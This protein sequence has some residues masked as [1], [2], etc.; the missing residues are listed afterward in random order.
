MTRILAPSKSGDLS[1][2]KVPAILTGLSCWSSWHPQRGGKGYLFVIL[3]LAQAECCTE[4]AIFVGDPTSAPG[5]GGHIS[6]VAGDI[7][8]SGHA[9]PCFT[10]L[11]RPD[12]L[13]P[14]RSR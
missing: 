6:Y 13:S 12:T 9:H 11:G 3:I 2:G 8:E 10:V 5:A 14:L 4:M 1:V 7:D